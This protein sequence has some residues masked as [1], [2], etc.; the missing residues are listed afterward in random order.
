MSDV[1]TIEVP[2]SGESRA[3]SSPPHSIADCLQGS[4]VA[5]QILPSRYE[6][7]R[8]VN[9]SQWEELGKI[10][11]FRPVYYQGTHNIDWRCVPAAL[12]SLLYSEDKNGKRWPLRLK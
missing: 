10:F 3:A 9:L 7:K 1:Q 11:G 4:L 2:V 8:M 5:N 12:T 6:V